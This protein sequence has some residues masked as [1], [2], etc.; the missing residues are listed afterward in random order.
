MATVAALKA[1]D[2][3]YVSVTYGAGG[4]TRG[5]TIDLAKRIKNELDIEVLAQTIDDVGEHGAADEHGFAHAVHSRKR[6][7]APTASRSVTSVFSTAPG[8]A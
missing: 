8:S 7:N 5:R 2:P 3:A 4:S 1:L 6:A